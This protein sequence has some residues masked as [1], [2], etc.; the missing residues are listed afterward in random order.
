M[1]KHKL[2]LKTQ[3]KKVNLRGPSP[4]NCPPGENIFPYK[5]YISTYVLQGYVFLAVLVINRVSIL[6]ILLS[7][8]RWFLYFG[9]RSQRRL[10]PKSRKRP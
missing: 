2:Q 4:S 7:N 3:E 1:N 5:G 10:T 9:P 6:A 8:R